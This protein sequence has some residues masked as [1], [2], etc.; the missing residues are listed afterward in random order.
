MPNFDLN[1][2][3]GAIEMFCAGSRHQLHKTN[4]ND[5]KLSRLYNANFKNK[6]SIDR[7]CERP[8][9]EQIKSRATRINTINISFRSTI[10]TAG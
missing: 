1:V 2:Y 5:I 7:H 6:L 9:T 10:F 8:F 4:F 3:S